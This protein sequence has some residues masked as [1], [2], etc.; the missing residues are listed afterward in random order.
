MSV[1]LGRRFGAG[2]MVDLS[3]G[4]SLYRIKLDEQERVTQWLRFVTRVELTRHLFVVSD[5]EY[6][7]GD[8]LQGP[9][10][11]LELGSVF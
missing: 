8:D 5:L 2:H 4:R 11:F 3:Y 1:R 9:R 7:T 6:D 10:V